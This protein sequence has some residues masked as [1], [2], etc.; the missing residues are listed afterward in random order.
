M[1]WKMGTTI[2]NQ[3]IR[4]FDVKMFPEIYYSALCVGYPFFPPKIPSLEYVI[5]VD[6]HMQ[7]L[8]IMLFQLQ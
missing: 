5:N 8:L 6:D 7:T 2:K 3:I 1:L 4:M